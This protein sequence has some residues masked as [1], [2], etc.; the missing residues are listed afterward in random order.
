[1]TQKELYL[2][3]YKKIR[4]NL[5]FITDDIEIKN[6]QKDQ[7]LEEF[8]EMK[9]SFKLYYRQE[10]IEQNDQIFQF[11]SNLEEISLKFC[12]NES[13]LKEM[14]LNSCDKKNIQN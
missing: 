6:L 4:Y 8:K 5:S 9:N 12:I 1:M 11:N 7:I 3:V 14:K 2:K 10:L 13:N